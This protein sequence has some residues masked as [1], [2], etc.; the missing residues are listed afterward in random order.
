MFS[1]RDGRAPGSGPLSAA[2][3]DAQELKVELEAEVRLSGTPSNLE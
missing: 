2:S 1:L 3:Q